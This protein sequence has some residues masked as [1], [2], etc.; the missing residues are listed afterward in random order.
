MDSKN[1]LI[2]ILTVS[3][4]GLAIVLAILTVFSPAVARAGGQ[5]TGGDYVVT[6][7]KLTT[8]GDAVWILDSRSRNVG[9]Y[10]YDLATKRVE[11]RRVIPVAQLQ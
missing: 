2:V 4:V 6:T 10:Q 8:G 1:I 7:A 3:A 9:V 5:V 11:L